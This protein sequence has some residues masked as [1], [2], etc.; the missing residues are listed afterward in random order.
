MSRAGDGS[1]IELRS[2]DATATVQPFGAHVTSWT[3]RGTERLFLS[4]RAVFDGQRAIRGGIPVIFPQFAAEG[5]LPKH[6]FAR[7]STWERVPQTPREIADH[8]AL[9][10][11]SSDATRA[12]WPYAFDARLDVALR[13][14]ALEVA[15][16]VTNT[17]DAE[18]AFTVALHT[19][20]RVPDAYAARV[21]GLDGVRYRDSARAGTIATQHGD[22]LVDGE[23]NRI[24][25]DAPPTLSV[26]ADRELFRLGSDGFRDVVVWNPSPDG[27]A[28]LDDMARGEAQQMLCVEAATIAQPVTLAPRGSWRGAQTLTAM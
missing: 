8:V 13:G 20:L 21:I 22:L 5:P 16:R 10:L 17:G 28:A 3:V 9:E 6:G 14:D 25:M 12:I 2:A 24:Y 19:Y 18:L 7:T 23:V 26:V 4:E 11:R 15:L 27:A 1:A